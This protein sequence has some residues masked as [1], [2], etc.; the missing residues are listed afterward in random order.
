MTSGQ[1]YDLINRF[2]NTLDKFRITTYNTKN[3]VY[4]LETWEL[5]DYWKEARNKMTK[6]DFDSITEGFLCVCDV[7]NITSHR[8]EDVNYLDTEQF[9]SY[10]IK[11]LEIEEWEYDGD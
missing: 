11:A 2:L 7:F 6:K 9:Q 5:V 4:V 3:Q 10:W 1:M 8:D